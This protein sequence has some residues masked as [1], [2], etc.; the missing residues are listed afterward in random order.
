MF[1]TTS[2]ASHSR[3]PSIYFNVVTAVSSI[4]LGVVPVGWRCSRR[5]LVSWNPT[6][7]WFSPLFPLISMG[8]RLY[9]WWRAG[10]WGYII[11]ILGAISIRIASAS[12]CNYQTLGFKHIQSPSTTGSQWWSGWWLQLFNSIHTGNYDPSWLSWPRLMF[13]GN[14]TLNLHTLSDKGE[15]D[16]HG[17]CPKMVDSPKW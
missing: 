10:A 1:H 16:S 3:P 6:A 17:V 9:P 12:M 5:L 8:I 11:D 2:G 7:S 13:K 15:K 4:V 14:E